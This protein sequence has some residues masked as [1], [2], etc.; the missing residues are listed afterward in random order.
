MNNKD[1]IFEEARVLPY[2]DEDFYQIM[3][4]YNQKRFGN[5]FQNYRRNIVEISMI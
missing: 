1:T 3:N 4:H 2:S 5:R